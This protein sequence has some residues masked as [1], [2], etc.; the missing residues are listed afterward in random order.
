MPIKAFLGLK[1]EMY[2]FITEHNHQSKRAKDI[3]KNVVADELKYEDYKIV[4]LDR[5]YTRHEMNRILSK[6]HNIAS[7]RINNFF[8]LLKM[9]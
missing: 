3:N 2:S 1:S 7:Y 9:I 6:D 4:L 5:S 8:C